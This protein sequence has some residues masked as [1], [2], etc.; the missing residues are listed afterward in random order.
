MDEPV[1]D[2]K[3][4]K[5]RSE[6]EWTLVHDLYAEAVFSFLYHRIG[7]RREAAKDLTQQAFLTAFKIIDKYDESYKDFLPWLLGIAKHYRSYFAHE[8]WENVSSEAGLEMMESAAASLDGLTPR[9]VLLQ[10]EEDDLLEGILGTL[11]EKYEQAL[12][13][14]YIEDLSHGEIGKRLNI[15]EKAAEI[16]VRRGRQKLKRTFLEIYPFLAVSPQNT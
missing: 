7:K 3:K 16:T 4:L 5:E 15:S 8:K 2:I 1:I 14:R 6:A 11:S 12:R 10:R 13:L 9:D